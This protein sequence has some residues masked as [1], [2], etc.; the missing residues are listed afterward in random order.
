MDRKNQGG[1]TAL[2]YACYIGHDAV[3]AML[4]GASAQGG[5]RGG[6]GCRGV[7]VNAANNAG[8]TP[9]MLAASCGNE[10][11]AF[12]LLQVKPLVRN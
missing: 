3:V 8:M 9:L 6:G 1:W 11:A 10:G 5:G 12:L 7:S 2:M 4:L